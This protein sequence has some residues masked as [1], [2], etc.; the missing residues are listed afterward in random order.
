MAIRLAIPLAARAD[1]GS[2]L[3]GLPRWTYRGL[4]GDATGFYAAAR[5]FMAAWGRVPRPLLVLL[6]LA[7][8][9]AAVALVL[10][11]RRRPGVVARLRD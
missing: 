5:E 4:Q 11:W 7:A 10:V 1:S 3:P 2:Q 9:A 6:A 8:L